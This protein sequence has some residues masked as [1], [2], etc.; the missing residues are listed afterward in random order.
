MSHFFLARTGARPSDVE[1]NL[2]EVRVNQV[3]NRFELSR[4]DLRPVLASVL[5]ILGVGQGIDSDTFAGLQ[6]GIGVGVVNGDRRVTI[7]F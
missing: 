5:G 3:I 6:G 2:L 7:G 4:N 1:V